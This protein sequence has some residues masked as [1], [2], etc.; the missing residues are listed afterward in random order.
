MNPILRIRCSK[1]EKPLTGVAGSRIVCP[2]CTTVNIFTAPPPEAGPS[3]PPP[4]SGAQGRFRG[5]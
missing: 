3:T 1:C 2:V 4:S 5:R